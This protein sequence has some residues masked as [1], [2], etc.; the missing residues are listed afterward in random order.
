MR[1]MWIM[2]FVGRKV[3]L[4]PG[5][6]SPMA[7]SRHGVGWARLYIVCSAVRCE[8]WKMG[9]QEREEKRNERERASDRKNTSSVENIVFFTDGYLQVH[10]LVL[11]RT[12]TRNVFV[13]CVDQIKEDE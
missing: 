3:L 5:Q 9:S 11:G 1:G 2:V 8:S 6:S 13:A 10:Y 7:L 4:N 12:V